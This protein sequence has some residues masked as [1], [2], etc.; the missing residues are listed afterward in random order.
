MVVR[1]LT[2]DDR[3]G[4]HTR[5]AARLVKLATGFRSAITL[6][7]AGER[8]NAKQILGLMLLAATP[9]RTVRVV[10]EGDDESAALLAIAALF[11]NRFDEQ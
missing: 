10:A 7:T 4:L 6:E 9:G 1:E 8:A 5:A 11:H 3:L 2:I